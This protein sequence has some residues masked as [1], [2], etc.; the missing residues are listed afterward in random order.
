MNSLD[1][2]DVVEELGELGRYQILMY[3]LAC[4]P[5]LFGAANSLTYVFTAGVPNYRCLVP[6][7]DNVTNPIYASPWIEWAIPNKHQ[8]TTAQYYEAEYCERYIRNTTDIG[9]GCFPQTFTNRTERC[10]EWVFDDE[11]TIVND[12][13]IT[14]LENQW[15]LSL[16]GTCHFAGIII[17]SGAF[18]AL[19]DRY[20][21]KLMFI[22]SIFLM[23]V[24]GII[25]VFSNGYV[26]FAIFIFINSI[27]TAGIFPLA[28]I[29]GVEMVGRKKREVT[30]IILNYFYSV[31]EALIAL[32]AWVTK[33][34]VQLQLIAS[35][36]A[37]IFLCYYW[38][39]PESARWLLAK[40]RKVEAKAVMYRVAEC[41]KVVLSDHLMEI[42]EEPQFKIDSLEE[43]KI[44]PVVKCM[45]KSRK[46]VFRFSIV[47]FI[48]A[49]N[50][51]VYYGLSLSSTSIGGDKYLNFALVS[52]VEIPGNTL[53]WVCINK[54][55]RKWSLAGSLLISGVTCCLT[56]FV[57]ADMHWLVI[58]FFLIGKLG[59]TS[60]FS[61]SYVHTSEMLPTIIRSGGV[62]LASTTARVGAL[63]APFVPLLGQY[64]PYL[65]ML[66][67]GGFAV[68]AGLL[69]LKLPETRGVK[70]PEKV[71]DAQ[72]L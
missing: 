8:S 2:D 48:W 9:I 19:A 33:D 53:A 6:E 26:M 65:P 42:F 50:A 72:R 23:S 64:V 44:L 66:L 29:I 63:V 39:L 15:M 34:W 57:P 49:V 27:G 16:V 58:V 25:Q 55:G 37:L 70:L 62:G 22:L 46:L 13:N 21:R 38:I 54:I 17:G 35:A 71:I 60:A 31:G 61:V 68:V 47:F 28:F 20:G 11:R 3:T 51:F 14:C 4:I 30:G 40:N 41:N 24:S 56:I 18:G 36:P 7:C 10:H 52:L 59:V 69:A 12:W 45:A 32:F 43:A 67:L 1:F 5:V